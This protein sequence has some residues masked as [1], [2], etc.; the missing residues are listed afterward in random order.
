MPDQ[1]KS[2]QQRDMMKRWGL[3]S[4]GLE[5]GFIIALPLLAFSLLGKWLDAKFGTSPWL[6]LAGILIAI[7]STTAWLTKRFKELIK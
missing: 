1:D 3:V 2:K 4:L 7:A 5:M 6:V